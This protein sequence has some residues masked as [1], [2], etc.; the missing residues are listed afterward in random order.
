MNIIDFLVFDIVSS[1]HVFHINFFYLNDFTSNKSYYCVNCSKAMMH[2]LDVHA[3][4]RS[5]IGAQRS[6]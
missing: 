5:K 4:A 6:R 2:T 1:K 3:R